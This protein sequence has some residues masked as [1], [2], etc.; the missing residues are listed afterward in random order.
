MSK[1]EYKDLHLSDEKMTK[2]PH[3]YGKSWRQNNR[4]NKDSDSSHNIVSRAKRAAL[5][6]QFDWYAIYHINLLEDKTFINNCI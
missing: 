1:L 4:G 3:H 6:L 2:P 5:P